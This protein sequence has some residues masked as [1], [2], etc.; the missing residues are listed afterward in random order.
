MDSKHFIISLTKPLSRYSKGYNPE[1][2][3]ENHKNPPKKTPN[4]Q[5]NNPRKYFRNVL[6][7]YF[8]H[9]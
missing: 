4:Q 9:F 6:D 7:S 2:L 1:S 3:S 8:S 5:D